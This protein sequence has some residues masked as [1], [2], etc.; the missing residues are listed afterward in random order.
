MIRYLTILIIIF[1]T[2][3]TYATISK[4]EIT[5]NNESCRNA[6]AEKSSHDSTPT[7]YFLLIYIDCEKGFERNYQL[8]LPQLKTWLTDTQLDGLNKIRLTFATNPEIY[9]YPWQQLFNAINA[10]ENWLAYK[11]QKYQV[12]SRVHYWLEN[13]TILAPMQAFMSELGCESKLET[14]QWFTEKIIYMEKSELVARSGTNQSKWNYDSY[15]FGFWFDFNV[16]C[17]P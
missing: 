2:T 11:K 14:P 3:A 12:K 7:E 15:P 4:E 13:S 9:R 1:S 16:E 8:L 6:W 10:D 17:S 5:F